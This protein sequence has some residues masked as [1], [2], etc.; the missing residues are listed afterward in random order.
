MLVFSLMLYKYETYDLCLFYLVQQ[1]KHILAKMEQMKE[2]VKNIVDGIINWEEKYI[3][4]NNTSVEPYL[5]HKYTLKV[6]N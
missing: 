4:Q 2:V 3:T 5:I 6:F 1:F